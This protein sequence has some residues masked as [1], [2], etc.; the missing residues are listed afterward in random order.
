VRFLKSPSGRE[1]HGPL[2]VFAVLAPLCGT[3]LTFTFLVILPPISGSKGVNAKTGQKNPDA[4]APFGVMGG[5]IA[6]LAESGSHALQR[7][8]RIPLARGEGKK[9]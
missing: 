6:A 9:F 2:L 4:L 8:S 1:L 7:F 3:Q 5:R